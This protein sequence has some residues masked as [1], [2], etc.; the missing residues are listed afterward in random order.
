MTDAVVYCYH[1]VVFVTFIGVMTSSLFSVGLSAPILTVV[2]LV[3]T[4]FPLSLSPPPPLWPSSLQL[5]HPHQ[6]LTPSQYQPLSA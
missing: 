2:C 1:K 3:F 5:T 6:V 4:P